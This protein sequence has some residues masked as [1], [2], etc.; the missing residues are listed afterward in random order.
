MENIPSIMLLH[1]HVDRAYA[2]FSTMIGPLA[3]NPLEIFLGVI[4]IGTYQAAYE[5]SR[6]AYEPLSDLWPDIEPDIDSSDDGS[7][8]GGNKYQDNP[9]GP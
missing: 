8:D 4:R 9:E 5:D 2:R 1:K 6:W 3:N 7:S